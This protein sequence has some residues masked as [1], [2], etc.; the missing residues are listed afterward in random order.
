MASAA[1]LVV[2]NIKTFRG[3][4]GVGLNATLYF[5]GKKVCEVLDDAHGGEWDF[6][7]ID[8]YDSNSKIAAEVRAYVS[9]L[10]TKFTY[11]DM[12]ADYMFDKPSHVR[13][14]VK[15]LK[16]EGD[17]EECDG[18]PNDH[19]KIFRGHLYCRKCNILYEF[20]GNTLESF[21]NLAVEEHELNKVYKRKCKTHT[22]IRRKGCREGEYFEFKVA[23][24]PATKAK[25]LEK[26]P[27][28]IEIINERFLNGR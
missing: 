6:H 20:L 2:K 13:T 4:D 14:D 18:T 9:T 11:L 24:S 27:D 7:W 28:T 3:H 22:L 8:G 12:R 25:I 10:P 15:C 1:R 23:Y 16:C 5:D 17:I 26:Y 19:T 21:I